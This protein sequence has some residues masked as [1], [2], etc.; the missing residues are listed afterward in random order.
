VGK[1]EEFHAGVAIAPS[2]SLKLEAVARKKQI[3]NEDGCE[4]I[5]ERIESIS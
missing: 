3:N 2:L 1:V 4:V 5:C